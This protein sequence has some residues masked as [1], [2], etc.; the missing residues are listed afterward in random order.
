VHLPTPTPSDDCPPGLAA[1]QLPVGLSADYLAGYGLLPL[2][3]Q[4]ATRADRLDVLELALG[5]PPAAESL[6]SLDVLSQCFNLELQVRLVSAP[7]FAVRFAAWRAQLRDSQSARRAQGLG[8]GLGPGGRGDG[9]DDPD[10]DTTEHDL[11]TLKALAEDAP[12]VKLA[13]ELLLGAVEAQASDL[14]LE[15]YQ[16]EFRVRQRID[17]ILIERPSPPRRL[18]LALISHLKL[19]A[20]MNIA[21]RRL[22]QDGRIKLRHAGREVDLRIS[23]VP[24]VHGESMVL[25]LLDQGPG[26]IGLAELGLAP[27]AQDVLEAA[28]ALPH[29]M[30]LVTG[31]TGSGKTTTLYA[32]LNLLNHSRHKIITVED[33]VEYQ[34]TGINQIQVKPLIDLHFAN[35]LRAIVRQD[36]DILMIGEIRDGETA[37]IAIQSA[38]TGHLVLSTLHTNDAAGAPHRL[39][40]MGVEPYL[41]ASSVVLI[42]AQRL[43]RTLCPHCKTP[44][45]VTEADRLFLAAHGLVAPAGQ[46]FGAVGCGQCS[47]TGYRGRKG[48]FEL[49]PVSEAIKEDILRKASASSLRRLQLQAGQ[50]SLYADGLRLVQA[51]LT[52]LEELARVARHEVEDEVKDKVAAGRLHEA[53]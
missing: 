11:A 8:L 13:Q 10:S 24:T 37:E 52:T 29:G 12:V 34:I 14:H 30:I 49:L 4:G 21:E 25:R 39:L 45:P 2:A 5:A 42:V 43:V 48:I 7:V 33:P 41:L 50:A 36:P 47:G 46:L 44:H 27:A 15:I 3:L 51:G 32:V 23:T 18:Y 40:D 6:A 22:P 38:L 35:A 31:P 19:R 9:L 1:E 53:G 28:I 16:N 20:Q 17:G 26:M